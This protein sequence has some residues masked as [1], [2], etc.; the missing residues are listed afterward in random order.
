MP[1]PHTVS[2]LG[3]IAHLFAAMPPLATAL[4]I[5]AASTQ[6]SQQHLHSKK[7]SIP[8]LQ[9]PGGGQ[10]GSCFSSELMWAQLQMPCE[11]ERHSRGPDRNLRRAVDGWLSE[12]LQ[13]SRIISIS[14][15][16]AKWIG[17]QGSQ[18]SSSLIYHAPCVL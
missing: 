14:N 12:G 3:C 5:E 11:T 8:F 6:Y 16:W 18:A 15:P 13:V 7:F 2:D 4:H 17:P 9:K 10:T 1:C